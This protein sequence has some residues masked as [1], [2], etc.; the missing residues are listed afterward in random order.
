MLL[1]LTRKLSGST[2][3]L[4]GVFAELGIPAFRFNFDLFD[5]Y[6]F[7]WTPAGFRIGDPLGRVCESSN[8]TEMVFYKGLFAIDEPC[9]IDQNHEE[10]KW[11]KSWLNTLYHSLWRWGADRR[12]VRL[13]HPFAVSCTKVKQ[14][15]VARE[16][17]PVPDWMLH[18][19]IEPPSRRVI[20]KNLIGRTFEAGS[21]MMAGIVDRSQLDPAY[22]WFTQ[23]IAPG[24]HDAT[25]LYVNGN[26]HSFRFATPRGNLTDWRVTQGTD[27]NQWVP[28]STPADFD[29]RVRQL[30]DRLGLKFGRLDFIVGDDTE[31]QFL[32]VNPC[33]Q[34]GW[35]D[36]DGPLPLHHEVASAILDPGTTLEDRFLG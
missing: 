19:G 11:V 36:E 5:H 3:M 22:P 34:F 6:K 23:E 4:M 25:V 10:T 7:S 12:L 24:T 17:F 13:F 33:G 30:M 21:A 27:A 29:D 32:E 15:E 9:E 26:V 16:F 18:F 31:P 14:M 2:D 28:W 1:F 8:V 35:L 20:A